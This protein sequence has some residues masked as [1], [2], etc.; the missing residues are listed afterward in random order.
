MNGP[1][2]IPARA[3][4]FLDRDDTLIDTMGATRGQAVPGDLGDPDLVRL[5]P[6]VGRAVAALRGAGLAVVVYTS[7][8]GVARGAYPLRR[9]EDV[10]RRLRHLLGE[11]ARAA[12]LD[13]TPSQVLDGVY[14]CPFH[15]AGTV[16][17]FALE[18][19]WRKPAP[20]MV[21]TAAAELGLDLR[22]SWAVGDKPRDLEA[23]RSAGIPAS[24]TFLLAT[25]GEA[26]AD[27]RDLP[28]AVE[29][30]LAGLE[31]QP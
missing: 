7:Q 18:H 17:R 2:D 27:C 25:S 23:A 4:V 28:K 13:L 30:I 15:P 14:C 24:R 3:G 9:V 31:R 10:N 21:L 20:G 1:S 8:G 12:G 22:R 6:G 29:R 5:L 26:G 16:R 19:A 11:E